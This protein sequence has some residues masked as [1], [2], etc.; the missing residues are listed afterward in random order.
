MKFIVIDSIPALISLENVVRV[1][2]ANWTSQHTSYG[3]K[4]TTE[5]YRI[6]IKYQTGNIESIQ[7]GENGEGQKKAYDLFVKIGKILMEKA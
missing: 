2:I 4:Y 7:C 3:K 5:H 6:D 1:D